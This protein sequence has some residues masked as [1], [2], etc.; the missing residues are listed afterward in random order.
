MILRFEVNQAEAFRRGVNVS[1]STNHLDVNPAGLSQADRDL[2]ADRLDGIDVCELDVD[3]IKSYKRNP[4]ANGYTDAEP[5]LP[6]RIQA[7][8]PTFEALM[9][10]I[11]E[12]EKEVK[13]NQVSA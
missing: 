1:K 5:E 10:A 9:E 8:L 6:V 7:V 12:N 11:R 4:L 13:R 3:G 2:I